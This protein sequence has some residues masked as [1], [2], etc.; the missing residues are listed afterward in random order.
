MVHDQP[1]PALTRQI[2]P[3]PLDEH[4]DAEARLA[5]E[6]EV[7]GRPRE[8]GDEPG[9]MESSALQHGEALSNDRHGALVEVPERT[10]RR[11]ARD[12]PAD[13]PSRVAPLLHRDLGDAGERLPVLL[14]YRSEERRVGKECRDGGEREDVK[15]KKVY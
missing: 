13:E 8:P 11:L 2:G 9:K 6:L 4:A 10:R 1:R 15:K 3:Y 12:S 5:E 7:H 14:E